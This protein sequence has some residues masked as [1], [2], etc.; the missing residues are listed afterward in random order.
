MSLR[1]KRL[2]TFFIN[3]WA[4]AITRLHTP[5]GGTLNSFLAE[6]CNYGS[7]TTEDTGGIDEPFEE[8]FKSKPNEML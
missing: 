2:Q 4:P 5:E 3:E 6:L 1:I 8:P 7:T